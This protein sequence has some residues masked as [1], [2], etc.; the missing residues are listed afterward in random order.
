[1]I[2]AED[3]Q[4]PTRTDQMIVAEGLELDSERPAARTYFE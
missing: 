3:L 1:M 2:V 4:Q